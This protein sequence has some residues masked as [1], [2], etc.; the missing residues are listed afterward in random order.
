[1][2][3]L[4]KVQLAIKARENY[5][6][7]PKGSSNIFFPNHLRLKVQSDVERRIGMLGW[8]S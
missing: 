4:S 2:N 8:T 3:M 7:R 1:M 5:D 6:E